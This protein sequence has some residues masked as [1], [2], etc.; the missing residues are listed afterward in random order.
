MR[1]EQETRYKVIFLGPAQSGID[2]VNKLT[3]GLRDRFNLSIEAVTKLMRLAPVAIKKEVTLSEAQRYKGALEAIG[4]KVRLEPM[5]GIKEEVQREEKPAPSPPELEPQVIPLRGQTPLPRPE[6]TITGEG[7]QKMTQCPQCGF[8]QAETD[9]CIKCGI[10]ISKFI[11]TQEEVKAPEG[12]KAQ[13]DLTGTPVKEEEDYTPWEDMTNLGVVTAFL[14][15]MKEVL[16]SPTLFF[17]KMPVSKG[18]QNPLFYG[19]IIGFLGG[20][21]TLLWQYTFSGLLGKGGINLFFTSY[22]LIYALFLPI[23]IAIGLFVASGILH[24]S[25]MLVGGSKRGFEATFR[26]LAY[27]NSTQVF[28]IL[29]LLGGFIAGIY[30]IVLWIIGFRESHRTTTGRAALAVFLPLIVIIVLISIAFAILIPII[31]SQTHMMMQQP[32]KF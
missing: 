21:F 31:I 22:I 11:K 6:T 12:G 4:A 13:S 15:T 7:G 3:V 18:I 9:E 27:T 25:L 10:I 30:N 14:R 19:V 1:E 23:L 16:F 8:V 29:P 2:Y 26:V 32:P 5:E 17:Q 24:V 28:S 20:L